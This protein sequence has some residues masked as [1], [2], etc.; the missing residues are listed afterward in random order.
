MER[1][2]GVKIYGIAIIAFGIYNLLG[3][4]GYKQFSLMFKP[5]AP[6]L[7][8]AIYLFTILYG[9]CAIYCGTRLLRLE[10]WAR[11]LVLGLTTVS[12]ISGFFLNK[13]VMANFKEFMLTE[14]SG[15][16]PEMSGTVYTYAVFITAFITLFELSIIYFFTRP[17]IAGQFNKP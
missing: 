8:F 14:Q 17:K 1:S 4:G 10:N 15:V 3:V 6:A 12:V 2:K 7:I 9:I 11:K 16:S 13:T 5:L